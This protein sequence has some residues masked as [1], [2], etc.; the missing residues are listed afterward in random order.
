MQYTITAHTENKPGV[1][2]RIADLF[3]RRQV[4]IE[5]LSVHEIDPVRHISCFTIEI[6]ASPERASLI[7]RQMERIVEVA[8]VELS[9]R[10][11]A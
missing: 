2:Y 5:S 6:D 8:S 11:P 10:S 4:N 3:L 7:V 9:E 1:L